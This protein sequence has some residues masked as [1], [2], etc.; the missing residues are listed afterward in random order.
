M[1]QDIQKQSSMDENL[2]TTMNMLSIWGHWKGFLIKTLQRYQ[3]YIELEITLYLFCVIKIF[4]L[5]SQFDS[6]QINIFFESLDVEEVKESP[7]FAT[8]WDLLNSLG[9]ALSLFLGVSLISIFEIFEIGIRLIV[10]SLFEVFIP[11]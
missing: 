5:S 7:Q 11:S 3:V 1:N 4:G 9:G 10:V 8:I 6:F 2:M